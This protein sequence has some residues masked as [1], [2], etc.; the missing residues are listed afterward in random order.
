MVR[1]LLRA[2]RSPRARGQLDYSPR[3]APRGQGKAPGPGCVAAFCGEPGC[4][5]ECGS[6]KW[7]GRVALQGRWMTLGA[8][9][10]SGPKVREDRLS[11]RH[12]LAGSEVDSRFR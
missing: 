6:L 3:P 8:G 12:L 7:G 10:V 11:C 9:K 1:G 2:P 5:G 4:L